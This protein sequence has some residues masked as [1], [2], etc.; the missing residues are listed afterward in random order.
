M[1]KKSFAGILFTYMLLMAG[2]WTFLNVCGNSYNRLSEKK[3]KPF[4]AGADTEKAEI[5]ILGK[6]FEI[7]ISGT[8]PESSKWLLFYLSVSDDVRISCC[9]SYYTVAFFP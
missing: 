6:I 3:I 2:A 7:D 4:S 8:A 5:Q 1:L 9:V